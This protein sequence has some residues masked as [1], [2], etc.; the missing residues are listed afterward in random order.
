MTPDGLPIAPDILLVSN[1][2][3]EA[4]IAGYIAGAIKQK[5]TAVDIEHFPLVGQ[6]DAASWPPSVGP[7]K[8]MPSGGLVANWNLKNLAVDVRSG[9]LGL[10]FA[11]LSFLRR[12]Q[13]RS[14]IIAVGDVYCLAMA[15]VSVQSP[16]IFVA[17]AKSDYVSPHSKLEC[18]IAK[19]AVQTFARD[20]ATAESLRRC[21]VAARYAG[22][23]MMDGLKPSGIDLGAD[24][25]ALRIAVLPGSRRDA[26]NAARTSLERVAAL[27]SLLRKQG[28]P[29]QAFVSLAPSLAPAILRVLM[30]ACGVE[31]RSRLDEGV[32]AR[33]SRSNLQIAFVRGSFADILSASHIAFGQAGTANEQA[34]GAGLPVIAALEPKETREKMS[35]YRMR[36]K[37]LLG[38]ALM[39]LP[40]D[41]TLFVQFVAQLLDDPR[42]LHI[43]SQTGRERMGTAGASSAVAEAVLSLCDGTFQ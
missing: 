40:A 14:V 26:V 27:A 13:R 30:R 34:A 25:A 1:G 42:R 17:T 24:S 11:Q 10:T 23:A 28:R 4:A 31:V 12:Q 16:T 6:A 3:G 32:L 8:S 2:Y 21:G 20:E 37:Q 7:Q 19:R 29:V 18:A 33:L 15:L 5:R 43:M 38:D 9:L 41:P 22:N 35:W 39:V 36:Q